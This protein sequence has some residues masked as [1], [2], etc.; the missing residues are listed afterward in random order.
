M[1]LQSRKRY[2]EVKQGKAAAM[3]GVYAE[4]KKRGTYDFVFI[5]KDLKW[6]TEVDQKTKL[7][8]GTLYPMLGAMRF[9][10]EQKPGQNVY[11]WKL[12]SFDEIK[13]FFDE[14]APELVTSTYNTSTI[15]GLKP[16][17]IGKDENHWDNLY[18][19]VALHFMT[20]YAS[21]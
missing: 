1:H 14:I 11:S 12:E 20:K 5:G 21:K 7:Y 15:Y 13:S 19:T 4:K 18:K 10:I 8:D 3:K 2:N 16:N 17:P 9:L 6:F